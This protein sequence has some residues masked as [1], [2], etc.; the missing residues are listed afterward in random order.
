MS[1]TSNPKAMETLGL[2]LP[3]GFKRS[4]QLIKSFELGPVR[5][6]LRRE[7]FN[8]NKRSPG[9]E[10]FCAL[11][12]VITTL[13]N[14]TGAKPIENLL[15]SLPVPDVDY[16]YLCLNAQEGKGKITWDFKC[17]TEDG[18][19]CGAEMEISIDPTE[20]ELV[21]ASPP[22]EYDEKG[23]AVQAVEVF[24][25]VTGTKIPVTYKVTTLGDQIKMFDRMQSQSD[26][27]GN[28]IFFQ[29]ASMMLDYD[30]KGRGLTV[31]ELDDLPIATLDAL[32]NANEQYN[33]TQIDSD[34]EVVCG[35][36]GMKHE[37]V[38]P[39][40]RWLAPFARKTP[41]GS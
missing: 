24:D 17:E 25:P 18:R 3:I 8:L 1:D 22:I 36:C 2:E 4:E 40:D 13:G 34:I 28:F 30:N 15:K 26:E 7:F 33:P 39:V 14:V 32:I 38:L 10:T 9:K 27:L 19:G 21:E 6:R 29:L 35:N 37:E 11:K 12:H 23:R 41:S 31:E 16:I 5:G 20:V